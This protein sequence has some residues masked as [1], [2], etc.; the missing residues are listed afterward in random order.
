MPLGS[1]QFDKVDGGSTSTRL[2]DCNKRLMLNLLDRACYRRENIVGIS[3]DQPDR[4]NDDNTNY[5][6]HHRILGDI[7]GLLIYSGFQKIVIHIPPHMGTR[8]ELATQEGGGTAGRE[9]K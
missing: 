9:T 5:R 6:Q 4:A 1:T 7:L 8:E 3:A 2:A